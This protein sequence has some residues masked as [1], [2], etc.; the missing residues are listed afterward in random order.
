ME[1]LQNLSNTAVIAIASFLALTVLAS[2]A[3]V[4]LRFK[5]VSVDFSVKVDVDGKE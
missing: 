5:K 4:I 2:A 1:A 3:V